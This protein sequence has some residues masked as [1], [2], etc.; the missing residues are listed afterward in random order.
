M[1]RGV[2][3]GIRKA[4]KDAAKSEGTSLGMWVRRALQRALDAGGDGPAAG[5]GVNERIRL[6]EARMEALEKSHRRLHNK[7][8]SADGR[9]NKPQRENRIE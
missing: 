8:L 5:R 3:R 7:L 4:V 2:D 1:I 6:I 9:G